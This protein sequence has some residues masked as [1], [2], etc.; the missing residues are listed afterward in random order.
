MNETSSITTSVLFRDSD[1]ESNTTNRIFEINSSGEES[2]RLRFDP[3]FED[4]KTVQ[5]SVNYDKNFKEDGHKLTFDFQY[6]TST[7]DE[8]SLINQDG[9]DIEKYEL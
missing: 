5:Y 2:N 8:N 6:E 1:N 9:I 4:D 3:E 7:E